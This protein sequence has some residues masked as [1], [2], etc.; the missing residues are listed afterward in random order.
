MNALALHRCVRDC[1]R[2]V[3]KEG[4]TCG[5]CTKFN[6]TPEQIAANYERIRV[7]DQRI[8]DGKQ[9]RYKKHLQKHE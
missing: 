9:A 2:M 5:T 6:L 3:I 7:R 4:A 8:F 1:G